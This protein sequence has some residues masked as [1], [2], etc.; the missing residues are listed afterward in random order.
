MTQDAWSLARQVSVA[1]PHSRYSIYVGSELLS[2]LSVGLEAAGLPPGPVAIV[3]DSSVAG[4]Y[5]KRLREALEGRGYTVATSCVLKPGE[6]TKSLQTLS[7]LFDAFAQAGLDRSAPILA[8]GGGVVGDV[9]GFAAATFKRGLPLVQIPTTLLAQVDSAVGGKVA[10]NHPSGKNLIGAFHQPGLVVADV[11]TLRTL[12]AGERIAGL[13]EV[14]KYGVLCDEPF[15][16]WI[17]ENA[18]ALRT[19]EDAATIHAVVRSCEIKAEVVADDERDLGRRAILNLGH[20]VGHAIENRLGYGGIRHGE[21]V[22]IGMVVAARI[23][24]SI[25]AADEKVAER[26]REV[27]TRLGLPTAVPKDIDP[28]EL[29]VSVRQDKKILA[30]RLRFILPTRIGEVV[31]RDD[32]KEDQILE[33]CR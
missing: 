1:L 30:G 33:A 4:H 15:F 21:A 17:D 16:E 26:I 2:S 9:A 8:L 23:A 19:G 24:A 31:I 29:V 28:E 27:A 13:A 32:I 6:A 14:M 10:V 7:E 22:A 18:E 20:T 25:G 11:A 12:P 5:E 3:T